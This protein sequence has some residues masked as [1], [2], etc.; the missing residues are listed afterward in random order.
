MIEDILTLEGDVPEGEGL[1]RPVMRGGRR[2][3]PA[4]PLPVLRDH[5]AAELARL[6]EPLRQLGEGPP[7]PV[8][9]AQ[10]LRDLAKKV[11]EQNR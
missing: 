8:Q 11:D 3:A 9:I 4:F 2:L 10:S 7:Y 6:P 1:I 5:A